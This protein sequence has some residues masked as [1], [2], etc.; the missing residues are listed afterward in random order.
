MNGDALFIQLSL[1]IALGGVISIAMRLLKQPLIIG[2]IITGIVA[3]PAVLNIIKDGDGFSFLSTFGVA[4]LLFIVGLELS[5]KIVSRLSKVV[6]VTTF[7]QMSVVLLAG[8]ALARLLHFGRLESLIIGLCLAMSSTIIIVTLLQQKKEL[9]RLFAQI[10]VGVLI[11]QDLVATAAKITLSARSA[12]DTH[13]EVGL[14]LGRGILCVFILYALSKFLL[15]KMAKF[16][17]SSKELLL[18]LSI[19][20]ALGIAVLFAKIGFSFEVGALLAGMSMAGLPFSHEVASRLRP[21]RDFFIIVFLITLGYTLAPSQIQNTL[22][23]A[24]LFSILVFTLKPLVI[25]ASLGAQGYTKRASF[26]T[27]IAMSQI[28]EFSLV[29]VV[30]AVHHNYASQT[31]Q[32]AIGLTAIITFAGSAY[33]I[34]YDDQLFTLL[35]KH[36]RFFER[37]ITKLEQKNAL[38][39][40]SV[41][42]FGY[43]KGGAEFI[44]TFKAMKKRF[45]VVDYDPEAIEILERQQVNFLYGDAT[46]AELIEEL[47]LDR[48]KLVVSTISDFAANEFLAHWLKEHN[49]SAV[50][51]ASAETAYH[52][53]RLYTEGAAYVMMPHFIGSE[54]ISTFIKKSELKKSEFNKFREKHLQ[55]L[56]T[57]YSEEPA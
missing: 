23:P 6:F 4:L 24:L 3:G 20:W 22:I 10:A 5:L 12:G 1:V 13:L 54:K 33:L 48:V 49:P 41:V 44:R 14:L 16:L 30:A 9:M 51:V 21:M 39:K 19:G 31:V 26:K 57:H 17:E 45:I 35:E 46:D 11:L 15:P 38:Q 8:S 29:F 40:Y 55:Y 36:L 53:A 32:A 56:E 34:K 37:R 47:Q 28:S 18:I 7:V 25:L 50:F 43:R 27:A 2:H 42:L 52:A